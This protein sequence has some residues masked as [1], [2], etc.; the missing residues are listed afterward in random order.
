VASDSLPRRTATALI[1]LLLAAVALVSVPS[2]L[3]Q[4]P[5]TDLG[6]RQVWVLA[7]GVVAYCVW[8][9][10]LAIRR[11]K[12]GDVSIWRLLAVGCAA[13][14]PVVLAGVAWSG[15]VQYHVISRS[16]MV[17]VVPLILVVALLLILSAWRLKGWFRL[18]AVA[19]H[20][21]SGEPAR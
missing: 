11:A 18:G 5:I 17:A 6:P 21:V 19:V 15:V 2:V 13:F 9:L 16:P 14:A 7:L 10:W 4:K 1:L 12:T 3:F 20:V 8:F